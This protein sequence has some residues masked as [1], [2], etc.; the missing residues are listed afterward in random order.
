MNED[1]LDI[2]TIVALLCLILWWMSF[3][4]WAGRSCENC[5]YRHQPKLGNG[6]MRSDSSGVGQLYMTSHCKAPAHEAIFFAEDTTCS[7]WKKKEE[8]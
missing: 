4:I 8:K 1:V 2:L 6:V 3:R 7:N 5:Y